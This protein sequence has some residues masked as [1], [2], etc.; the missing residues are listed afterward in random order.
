MTKKWKIGLYLMA[1]LYVLAG[2]NH[3]INPAFY[4]P[5][6]PAWVPWHYPIIYITGALEIVLGLLLVP[7][8]TRKNAA[9]CIIV[10]LVLIFP[11]NIQ[12]ML[13]Y[14]REQ[15]PHLWVTILRLPLQVVLIGWAWQYV[16]K[17]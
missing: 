6:M 16:K 9:V 10:L 4:K 11:A 2:I 7:L 14:H 8:S 5:I 12:M 3:F 13:N 15:N 1:A 17:K